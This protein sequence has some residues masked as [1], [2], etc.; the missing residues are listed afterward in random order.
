M[1]NHITCLT[2]CPGSLEVSYLQLLGLRT[3]RA[4]AAQLWTE[5]ELPVVLSF[6]ASHCLTK[7]VFGA[8]AVLLKLNLCWT[9]QPLPVHSLHFSY[10]A[11]QPSSSLSNVISAW[12]RSVSPS[13]MSIALWLEEA[14]SHYSS[15]L[16]SILWSSNKTNGTFCVTV[17]KTHLL[18]SCVGIK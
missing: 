13:L 10:G 11:I 14:F 2:R 16:D 15:L 3:V 4:Q 17:V 9:S 18:N 8:N 5:V 12:H 6:A 7:H 1:I